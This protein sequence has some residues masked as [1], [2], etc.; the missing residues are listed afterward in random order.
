MPG[1]QRTSALRE[2]SHK[3]ILATAGAYR[4]YSQVIGFGATISTPHV[5]PLSSDLPRC[6]AAS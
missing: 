1:M 6:T 4:D 3:I 2:S 5:S